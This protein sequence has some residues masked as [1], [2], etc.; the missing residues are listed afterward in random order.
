[1]KFEKRV[2]SAAL[3]A[4][5][6]FGFGGCGDDTATDNTTQ[7]TAVHFGYFGENGPSHWA[8]LS[9]DWSTCANG[10]TLTNVVPGS[11]HQ[12]P[13]NFTANATQSNPAFTLDVD[14]D[15][16][17]KIV[18]NGHAIEA[19]V[20]E[21]NTAE[22]SIT[23][24]GKEYVLKQF[25]FHAY[26]EHTQNNVPAAMETH[27]VFKADDGA[28]AVI[29]VFVDRN[30]TSSSEN[31]ELAKVFATTLP[32]AEQSGDEVTINVADILPANS[33]VY[34]YSGSLTTPPCTE[35][36]AWNV[37]VDHIA[38]TEAH[39]VKFTKKYHNNFRP[40]TGNW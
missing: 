24:G 27:F 9:A 32:D 40:I 3:M 34:S 10:L 20:E 6:A 19:E 12:S 36:V 23:I 17:F 38:L 26:S 2:V 30:A 7:E 14:R 1:M 11:N 28:L 22:D 37:Y 4:A 16:T 18:N 15:L 21:T 25:H 29:G 31:S 5:L 13:V 33:K 8:D 35:G 39:V